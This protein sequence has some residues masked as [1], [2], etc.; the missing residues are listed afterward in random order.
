MKKL[1]LITAFLFCV[2]LLAQREF[3][4]LRTY[5]LYQSSNINDFHKYFEDYL[6]PKLNKKGIKN[7]GV[8]KEASEDMP[9][10]FYLLIPYPNITV[11]QSVS[12]SIKSDPDNAEASVKLNKKNR[13]MFNRYATSLFDAFEGIP[14]LVKPNSKNRFF[15]LR[16]YESHSEDAFRRKVNMFNEG[17]IDLFE[18]LDFGSVFFGEKISGDRMPC[19]TYLLSFENLDERNENW[20]KFYNHPTWEKLKSDKAY[21]DNCCSSITRAYLLP[22]SYSQL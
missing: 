19:L 1:V 17:E 7:I 6:I 11:Y 12:R 2:N 10:K 8:F 13:P 3:Y 20:G 9:R 15:E 16:T 21:K 14:S 5:E 4:E 22:T 18:Q